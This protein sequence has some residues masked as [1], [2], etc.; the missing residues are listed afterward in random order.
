MRSRRR[1]Q[2]TISPQARLA[3]QV[4]RLRRLRLRISIEMVESQ[5][6]V[7]EDP[8]DSSS[9]SPPVPGGE[10]I[11]QERGLEDA[12][13]ELSQKAPVEMPQS[14]STRPRMHRDARFLARK[15]ARLR[16]PHVLPI[17]DLVDAMRLEQ[18]EFVPYVDP[19]SAGALARVLFVLESP[20]GPA[21]LGS[22]ML[23]PDNDDAT[24]ANMWEAYRASGLPRN[25]AVHWNAVPWYVGDAGRERNVT[26]EQI[27]TGHRY[28][29][30]LLEI[31]D[32]V[33]IIV[34]MGK[35]AQSSLHRLEADLTHGG[36][37][38][39][40]CIHPSPRNNARGGPEQVTAVFGKVLLGL[41]RRAR[42]A[43]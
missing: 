9:S 21:A 32:C 17:N 15:Q 12:R 20:A 14:F 40:D 22:G 34:A 19:D 41:E 11:Q 35:P 36:I 42:G 33:E 24:A 7:T 1:S 37:R 26:S 2:Q 8:A 5:D 25:T 38:V 18:G 43:C 13:G 23:S 30:H 4:S 10:S 27:R 39:I 29:R 16:E 28:L 6:A 3:A 31:A